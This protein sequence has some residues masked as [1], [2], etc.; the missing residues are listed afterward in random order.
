M[1]Q[2]DMA[3]TPMVRKIS[4]VFYS[5]FKTFIMIEGIMVGVSILNIVRSNGTEFRTYFWVFCVLLLNFWIMMI[6]FFLL[7]MCMKICL[8]VVTRSSLDVVEENSLLQSML[9]LPLFSFEYTSEE[10]I[11][12][13]VMNESMHQTE[14]TRPRNPPTLDK[15]LKIELDW[16]FCARTVVPITTQQK[17]EKCLICLHD[18]THV[19]ANVPGVVSPT[20]QCSTL[21]HKKCLLE[22]FYFNEQEATDTESSQVTCPS[23]RHVFTPPSVTTTIE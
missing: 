6:F 21:F 15:L 23:C 11:I 20:C 4:M 1:T 2:E 17:E 18:M 19:Y 8:F 22:W 9:L 3:A 7:S 10:E 12:E 13:A 16:G 5:V 14:T